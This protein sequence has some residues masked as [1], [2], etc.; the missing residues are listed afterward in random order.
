MHGT[1][2]A[3]SRHVLYGGI[4]AYDDDSIRSITGLERVSWWEWDLFYGD[5]AQ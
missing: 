4:F 5:S 2:A 3:E 1:T